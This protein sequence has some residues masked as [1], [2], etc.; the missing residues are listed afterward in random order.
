MPPNHTSEFD[1]QLRELEAELKKLEVEYNLFFAGRLPKLPWETRA[2][3]EALVKRYDRLQI[4]NTAERFRFQGLQSRFSAFCE[5]WERNLRTREGTRPGPRRAGAGEPPPPPPRANDDEPIEI[6]AAPS[7]SPPP[8]VTSLR[9]P[10]AEGEKVRALYDQLAA[11]RRQAGEAEVPFERF[12]DVVRAQVSKLGRDGG[13]VVFKVTTR[14][15]RV[16]FTAK[17]AGES[18]DES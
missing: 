2:R 13:E 14:D 5:L 6:A 18:S 7:T 9:D 11:A 3:V 1:R 4:Q 12:Q 8:S 10:A 17:P 15:G 16:A